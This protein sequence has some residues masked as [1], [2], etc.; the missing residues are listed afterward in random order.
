MSKNLT[1][2]HWEEEGD[3]ILHKVDLQNFYLQCEQ[4]ITKTDEHNHVK[5]K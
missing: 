1:R 4:F 3:K 2:P 5:T